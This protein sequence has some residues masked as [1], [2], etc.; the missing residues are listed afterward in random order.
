[1][2]VYIISFT[3]KGDIL[4]N[5]LKNIFCNQEVKSFKRKDRKEKLS[6]WTQKAFL[7]CDA[8]IFIGAAGIAV[9]A[10]AP[11]ISDKS[12]DPAVI[13]CDELGKYIIP[14]LSGHIG[15]ANEF[16]VRISKKINAI[17]VIT[18]ATDINEVWAV[19]N[20]AAEKN[21]KI[22]NIENIKYI[23]SAMLRN[24]N[25]GIINDI[26]ITDKLPDNVIK[27]ATSTN[28][29]IVLSPYIKKPY[30]HTL[31]LVPKCL[32]IGLGS[33]RNADRNALI[34]LTNN[35]LCENNIDIYAIENSATIDIKKDELSILKLCEHLGTELKCYSADELNNIKGNFTKSDFVRSITG[36]DNVCERSAVKASNNGELII[37]KTVGKD[38]TLAIA[39]NKGSVKE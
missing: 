23:S 18:T 14:I 35:I 31:N 28:C 12:R 22:N 36:T 6:Q 34:E 19:D 1:M 26:E 29:G 21:Y 20:W 4:N 32:S 15:R 17:P 2:T 16:A 25:I 11:H 39:I 9:R 38:V 24:E 37:K 7:T 10:I 5:K 27:N 33:K 3:D 8:I 30:I 13:V